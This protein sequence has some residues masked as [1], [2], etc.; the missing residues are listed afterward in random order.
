MF[1]F[2]SFGTPSSVPDGEEKSDLD[3]IVNSVVATITNRK[4][5]RTTTIQWTL[6]VNVH[7]LESR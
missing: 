7:R 5:F 3:F 4:D 6:V 2:M 1:Y